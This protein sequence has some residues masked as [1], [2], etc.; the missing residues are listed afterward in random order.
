MTPSQ[1]LVLAHLAEIAEIIAARPETPEP[2]VFEDA[3]TE[4]RRM[5]RSGH[6]LASPLATR[7]YL[8]MKEAAAIARVSPRQLR[9]YEVPSTR[10]GSRRI[11][12]TDEYASWLRDRTHTDV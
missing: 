1:T 2:D 9:R 8:T 6:W 4:L 3:A 12:P 7:D 10:I 5:V 11:V